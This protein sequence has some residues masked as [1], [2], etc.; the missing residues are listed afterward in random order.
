MSP[1]RSLTE[2][3]IVD[4][5]FDVAAEYAALCHV[6]PKAGAVVFFVGLV[7]DLYEDQ[8]ESDSIEY[9]ELSHYPGMTESQCLKI[10]DQARE[11]YPFDAV[12]LIHRVGKIPANDQIVMVAVASR[13][14]D[15][16]FQ[17]ARYIMDYLKTQA[18]LWKKEVGSRGEQWLGIKQK[19]RDAEKRWQE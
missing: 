4:S 6:A 9:L 11:K 16:A 13:H 12:R 5:D 19:D 7:R 15:N 2:V 17:A 3:D 14:R 10:I 18:T 8:L 1:Q